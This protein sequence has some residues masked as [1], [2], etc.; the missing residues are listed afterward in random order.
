MNYQKIL[1]ELKR[2]N[3]LR[4][5]TMYLVA[6]WL[7][8]QIV[9]VI[10]E[11]LNLPDKFD[12]ITIILI[13]A[14]LP[15]AILVAWIFE[16][17]P[18]GVKKTDEI[19]VSTEF[20][21]K[22]NKKLNRIIIAFLTLAITLLITERVF[23]VG[24]GFYD[25]VEPSIAVLPFVNMSSDDDNEYFS[26][27]LSEEL[28]NGLAKIQKIKVAAR[29]SAFSFKGKNEDLRTVGQLLNV[30][31]ILEG[32]VRKDGNKIRITAQLIRAS[33]GYHIWSETYDRK[34]EGIFEIQEEI[35]RMVIKELRI[36]L[37]PD[38]EQLVSTAST[39]NVK[40]YEAY[41]KATQ[42]EVNRQAADIDSAIVYYQRAIS[43]DPSY[44]LA[45]A[46]LAYAYGLKHY[47]GNLSIV[48]AEKL[49]RENIDK[50][51]VLDSNLGQTYQAI[52]Y[53]YERKAYAIRPIDSSMQIKAYDAF[54]KAFELLPNNASILASYQ[55]ALNDISDDENQ[56]LKYIKKAL[57]IDPLNPR[58]SAN[59]ANKLRQQGKHK[60]ALSI[61]KRLSTRSPEF[62]AAY[63]YQTDI[64]MH[65]G[66]L[67]SAFIINYQ[68]YLNTGDEQDILSR[69]S[70]FSSHLGLYKT[71]KYFLDKL[72]KSYPDNPTALRGR[73]MINS[74]Q[75]RFNDLLS[76]KDDFTIAFG[77]MVGEV[78]YKMFE[79]RE[80]HFKGSYEE[81]LKLMDDFH[82]ENFD[83]F[84]E[85][86]F[87][88][89]PIEE[90]FP[91]YKYFLLKA[92][93][94]DSKNALDLANEQI[95]HISDYFLD[96]SKKSGVLSNISFNLY[97]GDPEYDAL[98]EEIM[99][100]QKRMRENVISYLKKEGEWRAEWED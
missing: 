86:I 48:D 25:D 1:A 89:M 62:A 7:I 81:G 50:A 9:A 79:A 31:H 49:M 16:I 5:T 75:G 51:L 91:D 66:Q 61:L 35:S 64:Y 39:E 10:N 38:E 70:F 72:L 53:L 68:G 63:T 26:D 20:N 96:E 94:M 47:Y 93:K 80:L 85:T 19:E 41:L 40:A 83:R 60:D 57:D 13:A 24:S 45:Y 8:I 37:L 76:F 99:A 34:L 65:F 6:G 44:A 88:G 74:L 100:D 22:T 14:G 73:L 43:L 87:E 92:G 90:M 56:D 71:S 28:L 82:R 11:P 77:P 3:V 55:S 12:T 4:V 67:D 33:D 21:E 29:T 54:K 97:E 32:S 27:G 30:E 17:T 84:K 18:A 95:E 52:G 46:R 58:Y 36:K 98:K 69:L 2:R 23:F 42:W 78:F 15:V 59:Y